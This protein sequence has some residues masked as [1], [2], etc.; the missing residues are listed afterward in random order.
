MSEAPEASAA[1]PS[2][3][4]RFAAWCKRHAAGL[5]FGIGVVL[6]VLAL[7]AVSAQRGELNDAAR[8]LGH[9]DIGWLMLAVVAEVLSFVA[10][11]EMQGR[12][13]RCGG[14][15]IPHGRL[16]T[17]TGAAGAI[18]S[19]IP[20]GPAVASVFAFRQYRRF[21]AD[22][23]IGAWTLIATLIS[24][25]LGL[26]VLATAGLCLAERQGAAFDLIGVTV[27]VLFV[28]GVA[29]A[30]LWQRKALSSVALALLRLSRRL[31]GHPKRHEAEVLSEFIARIGR[32]RLTWSD[33]GAALGWSLANWALDCACL[34][35][36]YLAVHAQ[37]PW[38]ALLLAY[39]AGQLAS[40]LPI[41]PGG[42]GVVEG[43]MTIA[44]VAYGGGQA[45]TVGAVLL[46]RIISFWA[47]LPIG[48]LAYLAI[49]LRDRRADRRLAERRLVHSR[50][51]AVRVIPV[52]KEEA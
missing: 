25:A 28:T 19:S 27:G 3:A 43:S 26:S 21:G 7:W 14:V 17:M 29:T 10:F 13:L 1:A 47:F 35:C 31:S 22:D 15:R 12:L 9:L 8:E 41:T 24:S 50:G 33:F 40:N 51:G 16:V 44:L 18:A 52:A 34:A 30:V 46:Y 6:G 20:A 36:G 23:A 37:I 39:G 32:V 38:Q 45:S 49:V 11:A 2:R 4:R 48:W 42:L 5:R